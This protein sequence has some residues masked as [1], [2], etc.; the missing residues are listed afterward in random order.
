[1]AKSIRKVSLIF[2]I[3]IV[4]FGCSNSEDEAPTLIVGQDFTSTSVRVLSID[5]FTV[6]LSTIKFDS[7]ITEGNER[8]LLGQY[9]DEFFGKVTASP[10]FRV[11]SI[12]YTIDEEAELDSIGLILGYDTYFYNDTTLTSTIEVYKLIDELEPDEL[13]FYNTTEIAHEATPLVSF[14]YRPEP[15]RDSV[16]V[17]LP[18]SLG[19]P[20]FNAIKDEDIL[21]DESLYRE[22]EGFTLKPGQE[23]NSSIIG[24]S[25]R[26]DQTYL[27]FFYSVP[28]ELESDEDVYDL[29]INTSGTP[30]FNNLSSDV[31]GLELSSITDQ[32]DD[33]PSTQTNNFGYLQSGIGYATKIEFPS[34]K[35]INELSGEGTI[36][37]ATLRLKP[38]IQAY[39]DIQPISELLALYILDQNHEI[40]FQIS[41]NDQFV[42]A[43]FTEENSELNEAIYNIP[44]TDYLDFKLNELPETEEALVLLPLD[45]NYSINKILFNDFFNEDFEA[46]LIITYAIYE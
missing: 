22:L 35:N 14:E 6:S 11:S 13:N 33:L 40:A 8:L 20:I 16:Y 34:L 31:S 26:A 25:T 2:C 27:R 44:V 30:Y 18:Y 43:A 5:T 32:E 19:E 38:S 28:D 10:Y 1:M 15:N 23:D 12:N 21:N 42:F 17:T 45:Y 4:V 46:E 37:D 39:S 41:N 36:L 9:N 29:S 24:F 3:I 7:I